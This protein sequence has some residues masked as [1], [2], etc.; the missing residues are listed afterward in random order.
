MSD[1][2]TIRCPKC[3]FLSENP[4]MCDSCG[5]VFAK[6][7]AREVESEFYRQGDVSPSP[8]ESDYM[9]PTGA[10]KRVFL[11]ALI[12]ALVIGGIWYGYQY[13]MH[14]DKTIIREH[15]ALIKRARKTL[16][17]DATLRA[18]TSAV[19]EFRK[20]TQ[21]L[22][23]RIVKLPQP[24]TGDDKMRRAALVEA[25]TLLDDTFLMGAE[26]LVSEVRSGDPFLPVEDLLSLASTATADESEEELKEAAPISTSMLEQTRKMLLDQKKLTR[27]FD[28]E[29]MSLDDREK[30]VAEFHGQSR[31]DRE[32]EEMIESARV[33]A[34]LLLHSQMERVR[35]EEGVSVDTPEAPTVTV[36]DASFENLIASGPVLVDFWAPWCPPCRRMAPIVDQIANEYN[37]RVRVGRINVDEN[38]A[39]AERFEVKSIPTFIVFKEGKPIERMVGGGT[40]EVLR[41][42][43]QK[44]I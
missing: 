29:A 30:A 43:I 4:E 15:Q 19:T 22:A 26:R 16:S 20:Q 44:A 17:Q 36:T 25:N 21:D 42:L 3:G 31:A 39:L 37:G 24:E 28:N 9:A 8:V 41:Q 10:G 40:K 27:A 5:A 7:R 23:E 13:F 12:I 35:A 11:A 33:Q 34:K 6:I 1:T 32:R 14:P 38:R 18:N 2:P